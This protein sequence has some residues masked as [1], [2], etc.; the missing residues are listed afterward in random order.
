MNERTRVDKKKR[1]RGQDPTR[2]GDPIEL[3]PETWERQTKEGREETSSNWSF[4][5]D[6]IYWNPQLKSLGSVLSHMKYKIT[7]IPNL[8]RERRKCD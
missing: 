7:E 8:W 4:S 2:V 3:T 6:G 1:M 5:R